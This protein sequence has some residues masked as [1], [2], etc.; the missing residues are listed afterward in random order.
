MSTMFFSTCGDPALLSHSVHVCFCLLL[1]FIM[2]YFLFGWLLSSWYNHC[3][4]LGVFHNNPTSIVLF[5]T[6]VWLCKIILYH[7]CTSCRCIDLRSWTRMWFL[8]ERLVETNICTGNQRREVPGESGSFFM[9]FSIFFITSLSP[10]SCYVMLW[11]QKSVSL[12]ALLLS[13]Q[14][15]L[16]PTILLPWCFFFAFPPT[17]L[18][19]LLFSQVILNVTVLC[20]LVHSLDL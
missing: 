3:T 16:Y 8:H 4:I 18:C 12:A 10:V 6:R 7:T 11:F 2:L 5:S 19:T 20:T 15:I 17:F 13:V 9:R 14:L 1:T